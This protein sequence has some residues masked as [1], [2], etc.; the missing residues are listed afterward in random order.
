MW[1]QIN[2]LFTDK[3]GNKGIKWYLSWL[4]EQLSSP[5]VF[6]GVR[7]TRSLVLYV[8][9]VDR[10]FPFRTFLVAIVLSVLRYTVSDCPFWYLQTLLC[11]SDSGLGRGVLGTTVGDNVCQLCAT[12]RWIS[13]NIPISST[14]NKTFVENYISHH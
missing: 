6:S 11:Q 8:C 2:V 7:G 12:G 13:P 4:P 5:Q 1:R 9:F 10:C 14:K 3:D